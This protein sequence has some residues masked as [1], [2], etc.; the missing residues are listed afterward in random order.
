MGRKR[1]RIISWNV[2]G[3]RATIKKDFFTS[4][5]RL[6]PDILLLQT[7]CDSGDFRE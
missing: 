7:T 6:D 3:L 1:I 4:I 5:K 2:N